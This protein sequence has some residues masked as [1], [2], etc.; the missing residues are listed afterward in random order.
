VG[1][2][3]DV[4]PFIGI[5]RRLVSQGH[6]VRIATHACFRSFVEGSNTGL[7]FY[8]LGGDP[9]ILIQFVVKNR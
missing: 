9:R 8:P 7:E 2:R 4:Q 5:G 6:R 1:T 3:G